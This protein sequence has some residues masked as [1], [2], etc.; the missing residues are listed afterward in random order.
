MSA[1]LPAGGGRGAETRVA[2]GLAAGPIV[3]LGFTRFAY[4]LLL[5]GMKSDLHWSFAAAGGM[6]SANA[7]GYIIGAATAAYWARRF[8][9]SRI[10]STSLAASAVLLLLTGLSGHYEVLATIRFLGGLSTAVAFVLGSALAARIHTGTQHHRSTYLVAVYMAGVGIGVVLSGLIVP[11][12]T[13]VIDD[14]AS[15]RVGWLLLGAFAIALLVPA[16]WA[17]RQVPD[18]P[19]G[20]STHHDPI[21]LARLTPTFAWY[22]LY[23]AGYVSYMTF[24]VALLHSRGVGTLG[25]AAFFIV[26]GTASVVFT[27]TVWGRVLSRLHGGH[28]PALI[29]ALVLLGVLPV[30]IAHSTAAAL[31]SAVVFGA[32]FMAGPTAATVLAR[33][34][35][36]A[37]GW[38]TGI[39]LLT[40]AF[41]VG[42]GIGPLVAG[43]LS[44]SAGGITRGLWLS[45]VLLALAAAVALTQREPTLVSAVKTR[46]SA[47]SSTPSSISLPAVPFRRI[48]LAVDGSSRDRSAEALAVA[49]AR[50]FEAAVDVLHVDSEADWDDNLEGGASPST[51]G[52]AGPAARRLG[53]AGIQAV[54]HLVPAP[55]GDI[56]DTIAR[57]ATELG[58]DLVIA[59]PH[60]RD[61]LGRW[62]EPS[63]TEQ[64][65]ERSSAAVLLVA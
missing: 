61:R 45:V 42:Q 52:V 16:T 51:A 19:M 34:M 17:A 39:A 63:I 13:S 11:G 54:A 40:V 14:A 50:T 48:L 1:A 15:W 2:L 22:L 57:T 5:P 62:L 25:V 33:R 9:G 56:A 7:A 36:P 37:H 12:V 35:L 47:A 24:V 41:S 32:G 43:L 18:Q 53:D 28:A 65:T 64:L 46:A 6:N 4:A 23:G 49:L 60:H 26:L 59:A 44:D 10:F 55:E 30:L 20:G 58:A 21:R 31:V 3:A 29:S 27:L 38:T 8:G